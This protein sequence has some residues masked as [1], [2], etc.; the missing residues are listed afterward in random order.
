MPVED[1]IKICHSDHLCAKQPST[2]EKIIH[3][4]NRH[5]QEPIA[6][7]TNNA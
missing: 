7:A 5:K 6:I 3:V 2:A 1:H 4:G